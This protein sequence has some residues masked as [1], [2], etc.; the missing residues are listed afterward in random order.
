MSQAAGEYYL[1]A[2]VKRFE[3]KLAHLETEDRQKLHWPIKDLPDDA[4][5]GTEVKLLL[6]TPLLEKAAKEQLARDVINNLLQ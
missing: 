1:K 3:G 5:T 4:Q 2:A 6:L